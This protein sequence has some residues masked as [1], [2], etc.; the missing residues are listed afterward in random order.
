MID[1]HTHTLLSDGELLL[2][3]LVQR[4]NNAGY[5]AIAIADHVD[6]SNIDFVVPRIAE[7]AKEL[8]GHTETFIIPGA[9]ITHVPPALIGKM[10]E[11]A[12]NLGARIV[13]VHGETIAEPVFPGTNLAG[14]EA[15]ADILSHPGLIS[16]EDAMKARENGV[17]L[18]ITSRKGHSLSNGHVA[19]IAMM[20][21]AD[22]VLNTDSHAPGDFITAEMAGSIIRAAGIPEE[23]VETIFLNSQKIVDKYRG[24]I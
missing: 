19:K 4:A 2:S 11:K 10:V 1:L 9:E 13:V 17:A 12:R 15:C 21:G 3:E 6:M 8:S 20:T 18:E 14:I 16:I 24:G 7:A 22:M 23:N 5:R